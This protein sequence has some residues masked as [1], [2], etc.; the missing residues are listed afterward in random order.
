ML[1]V[2]PPSVFLSHRPIIIIIIYYCLKIFVHKPETLWKKGFSVEA[3]EQLSGQESL[4][5]SFFDKKMGTFFST[6]AFGKTKKIEE[7]LWKN[8]IF[9]L[10]LSFSIHTAEFPFRFRKKNYCRFATT[11]A[12]REKV[13]EIGNATIIQTSN[14]DT[15]NNN[16][17]RRSE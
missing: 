12:T 3:G 9:G 10:R 15:Q 1:W 8:T 17:T 4:P 11:I 6:T 14:G 16:T 2:H 7:F 13:E 5:Y